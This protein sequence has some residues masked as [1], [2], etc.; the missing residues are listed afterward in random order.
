MNMLK[1]ALKFTAGG[2]TGAVVGAAAAIMLAPES[3]EDLKRGLRD[4][5]RLSKLAGAMAKADRRQ[6]LVR[7][8]RAKVNDGQALTELDEQTRIERDQ[9]IVALGLGFNAPG[10]IA[11]QEIPPHDSS[12]DGTLPA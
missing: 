7:A 9:A 4:R 1:R 11:A 2:I 3:G 10:A 12:S 5:L 8:F 6:E